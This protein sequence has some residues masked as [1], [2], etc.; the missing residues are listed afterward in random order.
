[1]KIEMLDDNVVSFILDR[2]EVIERK[3]DIKTS[4]YGSEKLKNL[5]EELITKAQNEVGFKVTSPMLVEA[6]P[7]EDGSIEIIIKCEN[8]EDELDSRFSTFT[9]YEGANIGKEIMDAIMGIFDKVDVDIK[10]KNNNGIINVSERLDL[11]KEEDI[12]I[13]FEFDDIDK[14][15]DACKNV[16]THEYKSKLYKDDKLKKFYLV[17]TINGNSD[18]NIIDD[19]NKTCNTLAEYGKKLQGNN[20]TKAYFDEHYEIMISDDAVNKLSML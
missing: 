6:V 8:F 7:F 1:M 11:K 5:F 13:T 19:F 12:A 2:D 15:T 18:K 17:L 14:A 20:L 10:S 9:P 3:I 4:M 16:I